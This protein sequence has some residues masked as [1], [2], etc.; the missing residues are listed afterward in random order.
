MEKIPI[1][2][3]I[4]VEPDEREID[5]TAAIDWAG[6]ERVF[7]FLSGLR[8]RLEKE[9]QAPARFSWF[10]RM[11]PQIEHTYGLSWWVA[12]RYREAIAQLERAGDEIGLHVHA[13]RWKRDSNRWVT[14]HGDQKWIDHCLRMSFEA[15]QTAF[16]LPCLS[17]R[18][19]DHWMNNET[20]GSLEDLGVKFDLTIEPGKKRN[21]DMVPGELHTGALPD[22]TDTPRQPYRPSRADFRKQSRAQGR[23]LWMIPL[24]TART[25]IRFPGVRRA[26]SAL[27]FDLQGLDETSQLNFGL[28]RPR[29]SEFMNSLLDR[30]GEP[31]LAPVVRTD[32]GAKPV[33]MARLEQNMEFILSHPLVKR[34]QFVRPAEAIE[35]LT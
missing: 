13:W 31:Y 27:G 26:A 30:E 5:S 8:S 17:F 33:P 12:K 34:F 21:A 9:T 20:M 22:Y 28:K 7:E 6:F 16:G 25:R 35:L 11:D 10:M 4:D 18:F 29:F 3:C 15:Y 23:G 19:G 24:S 32:V 1:I 14:D 2:I